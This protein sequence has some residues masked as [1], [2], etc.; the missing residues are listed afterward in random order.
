MCIK[1]PSPRA[2]S[3]ISIPLNTLNI[4]T[5]NNK[6]TTKLKC[7]SYL[8]FIHYLWHQALAKPQPIEYG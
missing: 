3:G 1:I 5:R 2:Y 4:K 7:Y 8:I 6:A